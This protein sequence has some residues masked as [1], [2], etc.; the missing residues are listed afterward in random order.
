MTDEEW[1]ERWEAAKAQVLAGLASQGIAPPV[2]TTMRVRIFGW[3]R[4]G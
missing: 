3:W 4:R 1:Q 2:V